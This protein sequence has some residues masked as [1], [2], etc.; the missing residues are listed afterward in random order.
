VT[1]CTQLQ[2]LPSKLLYLFL[3]LFDGVDEQDIQTVILD[4]RDFT[5]AIG[6]RERRRNVRDIFRA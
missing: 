3:L 1:S 5:F 2:D 4:S 6:D